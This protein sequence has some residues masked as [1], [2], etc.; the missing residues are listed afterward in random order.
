LTGKLPGVFI[1]LKIKFFL[2]RTLLGVSKNDG[3]GVQKI[4]T[5]E[6]LLINV[7]SRSTGGKAFDIK[8]EEVPSIPFSLTLL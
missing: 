3:G 4:K 7:G 5:G 8:S 6:S 1:Q 2:L